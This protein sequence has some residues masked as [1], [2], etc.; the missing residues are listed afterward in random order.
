MSKFEYLKLADTVAAEIA[1]GVLKVTVP[2]P[3]P[4]QAKKIEIKTAA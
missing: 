3:A 1:N 4:K 2:K